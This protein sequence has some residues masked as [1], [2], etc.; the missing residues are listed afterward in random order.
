VEAERIDMAIVQAWHDAVNEGEID[1]L[2]ELLDDDVEF[3]GPRGSGRGATVVLDWARHSGI[4]LEPYRWFQRGDDVVVEEIATWQLP[5]TGEL[6][7]PSDVSTHFKVRNDLVRRVVR[8]DSLQEALAAA[9]LDETAEVR[10]VPSTN[11]DASAP[12]VASPPPV[13]TLKELPYV[14]NAHELEGY[15]HG[16]APVSIIFFDG[17]PGSGPSLHR[18]PYA[19]VFIVQ[20]GRATFTV[21]E[22]TFEVTGGQIAVAPAN[23]PHKFV[24]SGDGP[25]RQ[26]DIHTNDRFVTKWL[27]D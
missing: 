24:N 5:D 26:I 13:I 23:V 25:L 22:A 10:P 19:E 11:A 12:R 21:G 1:R 17:P 15:L 14:G 9:G 27:E 20:E 8:Y 7:P 18:H 6:A 16:E 3:G 4:H 2:A